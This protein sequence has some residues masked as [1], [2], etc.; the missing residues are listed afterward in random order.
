ARDHDRIRAAGE[1]PVGVVQIDGGMASGTR[2]RAEFR[3]RR[4]RDDRQPAGVFQRRQ[5]GIRRHLDPT[6][7]VPAGQLGEEAGDRPPGGRARYTSVATARSIEE[8]APAA[9]AASNAASGH[10]R[11]AN[12][13]RSCGST[14]TTSYPIAARSGGP[15][16]PPSSSTRAGGAGRRVWTN[17]A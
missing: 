8:S 5:G 11:S 1:Q 16:G 15:T 2:Q 10:G 17:T 14:P 7:G 12:P 4:E 13:G 6:P 3:R 9:T